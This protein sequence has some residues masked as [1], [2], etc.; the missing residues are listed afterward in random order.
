MSPC[1]K[2]TSISALGTGLL[3][4]LVIALV[5]LPSWYTRIDVGG[6]FDSPYLKNFHKTEYSSEHEVSFRWSRPEAA[7]ILPG[8][9]KL[10]SLELRLHS[11]TTG[12]PLRLY[13][14]NR[15]ISF[16]VRNGWQ[17]VLLLPEHTVWSGDVTIHMAIPAQV[18]P[19]DPRERGIVLDTITLHGQEGTF[20]LGPAILFGLCIAMVT[21]LMIWLS[22]RVWAGILVGILLI[23]IVVTALS[24][25]QG[26]YRLFIT[27]FSERLLL[28]LVCANLLAVGLA[29][30]L[31]RLAEQ[32]IVSL[33]VS[34]RR[35]LVS[36]ALIAF[37]IRFGAMAYPLTYISDIWPIMNRA[38]M[39]RDGELMTL[40]FPNRA[41]TPFQWDM[42]V[43][44]PRSPFYYIITSPLTLLPGHGS[45]LAMMAFSSAVDALA[46]VLVAVLVLHTGGS[47]RAAAL[48]ALLAGIVPLGLQLVASWGIFPTLLA[49]CLVLL[50]AV[51]WLFLRPQLH[52]FQTGV[53]WTVVLTLA[54]LAYPTALVFFGISWLCLLMLLILRRD[55]STV[56]TLLAGMAAA[57][58]AMIFFYGWHIP[59]FVSETLP[60]IAGKL[61]GGSLMGDTPSIFEIVDSLWVPLYATYGLLLLGLALGGVLLVI[62]STLHTQT[63]YTS[64]L[65]LAWCAAY[66]PLALVDRYI[67]TLILK[68]I[69]YVLP[70][71]AIFGGLFLG[72]LVQR[73]WGNA[74][75]GAL[76]GLIFWETL[77]LGFEI[78]VYAYPQLK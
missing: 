53:I 37:V 58:L 10:S 70:I 23:S 73:R 41:L 72:K 45:Y 78:I 62:S 6:L 21:I 3:A 34:G 30:L 55:S 7:L 64:I 20:L 67:A 69:L 26:N 32:G 35:A 44:I 39:V 1:F 15:E 52:Q 40:F 56:P 57:S 74:V 46:V 8:V 59:A 14:G 2:Y 76:L 19:D 5:L 43:T 11:N 50:V 49:Q 25:Q 60:E 22:Q 24:V 77:L 66:P 36:A 27:N 63:I 9:G 18:S 65:L 4:T 75:A 13:D 16:E 48:A 42:D 38:Q 61:Q 12:L 47:G 28:V 51:L 54:Y 17:H 71:L 33:S 31:A 68:H 29:S